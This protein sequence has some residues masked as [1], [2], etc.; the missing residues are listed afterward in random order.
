MCVK[1]ISVRLNARYIYN[2]RQKLHNYVPCGKCFECRQKKT[3]DMM[4]RA[5]YDRSDYYVFDTLTYSED[6]VPYLDDIIKK[7]YGVTLPYSHHR[8]LDYRDYQLFMKRLR[9]RMSKEAP[10]VSLK[11]IVS[12]EYGTAVNGTHRPHYHVILGVTGKIEPATLS[13]WIN[14]AWQLGRTDGIDY[15]GKEYFENQRVFKGEEA[16]KNVIGYLCKYMTKDSSYD[17][18]LKNNLRYVQ[19]ALDNRLF[20][21]NAAPIM[22]LKIKEFYQFTR[23]SKGFGVE[24][25]QSEDAITNYEKNGFIQLDT[26]LQ[27]RKYSLP[28][29]YQRKIYREYD[30][31]TDTYQLNA[32]GKQRELRK[33]QNLARHLA[34]QYNLIHGYDEK[35]SLEIAH[36]EVYVKDRLVVPEEKYYPDT[37]V[38]ILYLNR[39]SSLDIQTYP[40]G[41][42]TPVA[43]SVMCHATTRQL[44]EYNIRKNNNP[45]YDRIIA[46]ARRVSSDMKIALNEI[47]EARYLKK[48]DMSVCLQLC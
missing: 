17:R 11:Y 39:S 48:K 2:Y 46:H 19:K 34:Q 15:K 25:T 1:P 13:R 45:V 33:M 47:K 29:Y 18:I 20:H 32:R 10:D 28:L 12:G 43:S 3:K 9:K 31:V 38:D 37:P 14:Q 6:N 30:K 40:D 26:D 5:Y 42:L 21:N 4:V 8:V 41:C 22:T 7:R 35:T 27:H 16:K 44:V 36:Y 24:F 23:W